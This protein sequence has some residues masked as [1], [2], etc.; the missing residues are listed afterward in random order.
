MPDF[1]VNVFETTKRSGYNKWKFIRDSD[2]IEH[3][4]WVLKILCP[5]NIVLLSKKTHPFSGKMSIK[6]AIKS[7]NKYKKLI[8]NDLWK[9]LSIFYVNFWYAFIDV[10]SVIFFEGMRVW[11]IDRAVSWHWLVLVFGSFIKKNTGVFTFSLCKINNEMSKR[12][13]KVSNIMKYQYFR[14]YFWHLIS[15]APNSYPIQNHHAAT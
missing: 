6:M 8:W 5:F 2:F 11:N 13:D 15:F 4:F 10:L 14:I 12:T 3:T 7:V 1:L 9:I